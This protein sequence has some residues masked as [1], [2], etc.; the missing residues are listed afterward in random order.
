MAN[1]EGLAVHAQPLRI[2]CAG[3]GTGTMPERQR[4]QVRR[5]GSSLRRARGNR[6]RDARRGNE[7]LAGQ[8][9]D[10]SSSLVVWDDAPTDDDYHHIRTGTSKAFETNKT[11][12]VHFFQGNQLSHI[13]PRSLVRGKS[14]VLLDLSHN[15]LVQLP[16]K[17]TWAQLVSLKCL[18]LAQNRIAHWQAVVNISGC[19]K[20]AMLTLA[21]NP[22]AKQSD[23]RHFVLNR[24]KTLQ[25]LDNHVVTDTEVMGGLTC[26]QSSRFSPMST[27]SMLRLRLRKGVS[28]GDMLS[29][30]TRFMWRVKRV[31]SRC[32]AL[33]RIQSLFRGHLCR[34]LVYEPLKAVPTA[35]TAIQSAARGFLMRSQIENDVKQILAQSESG[36]QLMVSAYDKQRDRAVRRLQQ[37]FREEIMPRYETG[38][39]FREVQKDT[40]PREVIEPSVSSPREQAALADM[41]REYLSSDGD[42][43]FPKQLRDVKVENFESEDVAR[44][45][46]EFAADR[47]A[48]E[49]KVCVSS[50]APEAVQRENTSTHGAYDEFTPKKYAQPRSGAD[51]GS[52]PRFHIG[53]SRE[54]PHVPSL[55]R[56]FWWND[57]ST[58]H[59]EA[60]AD[61]HGR[62]GSF[63]IAS[64]RAHSAR[65][66][67]AHAKP[68]SILLAG[69][70]AFFRPSTAAGCHARA[71]M[72]SAK[73]QREE[74]KKIITLQHHRQKH[75]IA[76]K[77]RRVHF[78]RN[79]VPAQRLLSAKFRE[80]SAQDFTEQAKQWQDKRRRAM[81]QREF[82]LQEKR[83][84]VA[85][86]RKQHH[87]ALELRKQMKQNA[88]HRFTPSDESSSDGATPEPEQ[89]ACTNLASRVRRRKRRDLARRSKR[90]AS[91]R[92]AQIFESATNASLRHMRKGKSIRRKF[93]EESDVKQ[94]TASLRQARAAR[95]QI[96][97][98][99]KERQRE[100]R[101]KRVRDSREELENMMFYR[102]QKDAQKLEL[103]RLRKQY[104][105]DVKALVRRIRKGDLIDHP[106]WG[107]SSPDPSAQV[108]APIPPDA[109][110]HAASRM[111]FERGPTV[112]RDYNVAV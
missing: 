100:E 18:L 6:R 91:Q 88:I 57:S 87:D 8:G 9:T 93:M 63:G 22:V 16:L 35:A 80:K 30:I 53:Q 109:M 95:K 75:D 23:Y 14:L 3:R 12:R 19:P 99:A 2:P 92:G 45:S 56:G 29:Q 47:E 61:S 78:L 83:A 54:P 31:H 39:K 42:L 59:V 62:N 38:G 44:E 32:S 106:A 108:Y 97:A 34:K 58:H 36:K 51:T 60:W 67:G 65:G 79:I 11:A 43:M 33:I 71:K 84:K 13:Q 41:Y 94:R 66:S 101:Q 76:E 27:N 7:S 85:E 74:S 55:Q 5:R 28:G 24:I 15:R 73:T 82:E 111:S 90:I 72:K 68:A 107:L 52:S 25:L 110:A 103:V 89:L 37:F 77:K 10:E 1:H 17:E 96:L 50:E 104:D 69:Q 26:T 49:E 4:Q 98:V 20:L 21:G 40:A 48:N 81:F 102:Q 70:S 86:R 112:Q 105:N 46:S 64:R